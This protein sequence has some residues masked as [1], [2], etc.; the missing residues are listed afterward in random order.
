MEQNRFHSYDVWTHGMEC[1]DACV[2]DPILRMAALFHDVGKPRT[3]AL[4]DKTQ[5]YTFYEH[6]R[7][8]AEMVHPICTRLRFSNDERAR[9][10]DLVRYHLFHYTDE[11]TDAAVRRWIRRVGP[12]RV[13][14]LYALN[15]ADVRAKGRDFE[16]D[17][18]ALEALKA[19]VAKVLAYGAALTTKDLKIN[20]HDLMTRFAIKPGP[21]LKEVLNALL[22]VVTNEP[23]ANERETLL[24]KAAELVAEKLA[25]A[26]ED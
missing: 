22:E 19:H 16:S 3:R 11:W 7:I 20:G 23:E 1:L 17:L 2:G 13:Q 8:G 18:A 12:E 15:E 14:D 4:S 5:D 25:R 10:A 21:I 9:I 26:S 24:V 6:E